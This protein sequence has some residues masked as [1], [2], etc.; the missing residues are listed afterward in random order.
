VLVGCGRSDCDDSE[1]D[2]D[3]PRKPVPEWAR[4]Q[5][6]WAQLQAQIK[7]DPDEIFQQH[8]KTC[9]LNEVF[10]HAGASF[11]NPAC[12]ILKYFKRL[13]K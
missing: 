11:I 2:D 1:D 7:M 3:E 9:A 6:L 10:G 13:F 12:Y 8:K 5:A 4:G